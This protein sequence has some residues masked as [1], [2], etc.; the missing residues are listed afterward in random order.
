MYTYIHTLLEHVRVN[1]MFPAHYTSSA[2][3]WHS[4]C[5]DQC[6]VEI[7]RWFEE[8]VDAYSR[9]S[10]LLIA[11]DML[12][13]DVGESHDGCEDDSEV[14]GSRAIEQGIVHITGI[15]SYALEKWHIGD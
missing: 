14:G 1:T 5:C 2:L 3:C 10:I 6:L 7:A 13:L 4:I 11:S 9:P 8:R 12:M 15:H